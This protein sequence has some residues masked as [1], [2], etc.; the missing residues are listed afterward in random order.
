M[1]SE[2]KLILSRTYNFTGAELSALASGAAWSVFFSDRVTQSEGE[3]FQKKDLTINL[4]DLLAQREKMTSLFARRTDDVLAIEN[5]AKAIS[6]PASYE[7]DGTYD[8]TP[9]SLWG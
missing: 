7:D 8:D 9:S 2:W 1:D 4:S 6:E 3:S 5:R